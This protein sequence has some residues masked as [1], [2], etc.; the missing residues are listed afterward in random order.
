MIVLTSN[1]GAREMAVKN[2]GF[3]TGAQE[4][5]ED[6]LEQIAL[7]A[8]KAKF[9]P[10]FMNRLGKVVMFHT[11]TKEH[12]EKI[13]EIEL[14]NLRKRVYNLGLDKRFV[15]EVSP[16]AKRTLLAEGFDPT[17]GARHLKRAIEHRITQP[18]AKLLTSGQVLV[19]E[20]VVID[21]SGEPEFDFYI[22]PTP[23]FS[24]EGGVS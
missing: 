15:L 7:S 4:Y 23:S 18:L 9:N 16:K 6:R 2:M 22:H 14:D 3:N 12:T 20:T 24:L 17:Y 8:A 13:L 19:G 11:L 10:E 1:L 5:E 21:D